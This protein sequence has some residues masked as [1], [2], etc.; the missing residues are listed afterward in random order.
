VLITR[1]KDDEIRAFHNVCTHRGTR[2]VTA[3]AGKAATF[4]CRY[5]MWT[6]GGDGRLLSAPDFEQFHVSKAECSLPKISVEVVAGL[7]FLNF[8]EA[9]GSLRAELGELADEMDTLPVARATSFFEYTYEIAANWKLTYDNFQENYH[10]RFIHP[11]SGAAAI[12]EHNAFGYPSRYRF[13]GEHR[14]QTIWSNP[15][16]A[17][18]MTG[19]VQLVAGA[20]GYAALMAKGLLA[21]P[22]GS[23]YYAVFPSFFQFGSPFQHFSHVVYPIAHNR[24]RGVIRLYW[25]G[26]AETA[27]E[28]LAREYS[29]AIARDIHSEDRAVIEDGQR[30]LSSGA[31]KYMHFQT[32][33]V[34]C[35]HLYKMVEQRVL[36]WRAGQAA[37]TSAAG[38]AA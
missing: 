28:L 17:A 2:L 19:P 34:L 9:P 5:H 4:S 32:Q 23:E 31:L 7:I 24:S 13:A 25:V 3:E 26:E 21:N 36:A 6:F 38:A 20:Q 37:D 29:L 8:A 33:E 18:A 35:R 30:G 16:A 1:G 14:G 10:L 15:D 11:G 22:H 27:G 12:G